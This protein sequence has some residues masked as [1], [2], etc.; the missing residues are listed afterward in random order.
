MLMRLRTTT[1]RLLER[2]LADRT[3]RQLYLGL[4][5]READQTGLQTFSKALKE[6][7]MT[8]SQVA[9]AVVASVEFRARNSPRMAEPDGCLPGEVESMC[10]LFADLT[11]TPRPGYVTD[12][13]G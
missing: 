2:R 6:G 10:K 7:S 5:G 1:G 9:A 3:V 13:T 4:L 11:A 12:F 8:V